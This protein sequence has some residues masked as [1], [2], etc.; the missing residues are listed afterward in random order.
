VTGEVRE[1]PSNI[2][3]AID[4]GQDEYTE[5]EYALTPT[6]NIADENLCFRVTDN[7][8]EFDTYLS[9]AQLQIRFDPFIDTPFLNEGADITL[10]AG[11]TTRV[12]AT[13]TATDLNGYNDLAYATSTF[14]RSG[15][16]A[17]CT[18]DNNNCYISSCTFTNCAGN[19]C[20][21]SC[22]A[23]IYFHADAT[24]IAPYEG[25]GWYAFIEV[26]DTN[27]GYDFD[28]TPI[29]ELLSLRAI[30]V[31]S[32]ISYGSLA[33]DADTGS[34]NASTTVENEGNVEINIEVEGSDMSD[35]ASSTIP[36]Y[37]QKFATSTFTY[38]VC[39]SCVSLSSTTPYELDVDLSKPTSIPPTSDAVY[40]GV[41]VPYGANSVAHTGVNVF[42]PVSP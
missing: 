10:T 23:D 40:W 19:S 15:E 42:T 3:S 25:E 29:E 12:Y 36:A 17:A 4:I 11:T 32:A 5:V 35:G 20:T 27:A 14:Y 13:T 37:E 22:Y 33:V 18:P 41:R 6:S 26:E 39:T 28:T 2:T 34:S 38:G 9:V 31:N 8:T 21:V 7:G 1:D 30:D 16:G 24:D